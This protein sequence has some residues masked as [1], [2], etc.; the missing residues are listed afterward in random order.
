[1]DQFRKFDAHTGELINGGNTPTPRES[2]QLP[3]CSF[4]LSDLLADCLPTSTTRSRSQSV[5][6][7]L[8]PD[9]RPA[10]V[11][12]VRHSVAQ[13]S[14]DVQHGLEHPP[15]FV[16]RVGRPVRP[17]A[18]DEPDVLVLRVV[19][20][21]AGRQRRRRR[22]L[23]C[24]H[25]ERRRGRRRE[26]RPSA[27]RDVRPFEHRVLPVGPTSTAAVDQLDEPERPR[28]HVQVGR[29][30]GRRTE[31]VLGHSQ[32]GRL[33]GVLKGGKALLLRSSTCS[34]PLGSRPSPADDQR[35]STGSLILHPEPVSKA[36]F[37]FLSVRLSP[38]VD[39]SLD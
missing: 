39:P 10:R 3:V 24:G 29:G 4:S 27:V 7:V 20:H 31:H 5:R 12:P 34:L 9:A 1:M 17:V 35:S 32:P 13:V 2:L 16:P 18:Q 11:H 14:G 15:V 22:E 23:G 6:L 26:Q 37:P 38:L 28:E 21:L 8:L 33:H 36:G 30:R 25:G 19:H